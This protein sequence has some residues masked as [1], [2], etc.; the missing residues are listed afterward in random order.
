MWCLPATTSVV[1]GFDSV[2]MKG[3][4]GHGLTRREIELRVPPASIVQS[5]GPV[6][7]LSRTAALKKT[8]RKLAHLE[9]QTTAGEIRSNS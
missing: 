7:A 2:L 6:L 1:E 8:R 9:C 4:I 5:Q 3:R